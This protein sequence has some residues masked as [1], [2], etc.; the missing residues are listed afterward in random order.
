MRP[1]TSSKLGQPK[2]SFNMVGA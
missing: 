2:R 1:A